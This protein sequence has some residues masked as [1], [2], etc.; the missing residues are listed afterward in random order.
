[1]PLTGQL[2]RNT[3]SHILSSSKTPKIHEALLLGPP[4]VPSK[5][6]LTCPAANPEEPMCLFL[7]TES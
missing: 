6:W 4:R 7:A 2:E 3:E 5:A 1:M